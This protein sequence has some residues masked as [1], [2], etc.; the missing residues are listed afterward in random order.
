MP[1]PFLVIGGLAAL[2]AFGAKKGYDAYSDQST[3]NSVNEDATE[4]IEAAK[5]K[6]KKYKK[7]CNEAITSLG[8]QKVFVLDNSV[9]EFLET[10]SKIRNKASFKEANFDDF[11]EGKAQYNDLKELSSMATSIAGGLASGSVAGAITAFGAYGAVS[12][13]AAAS[14]GTAISTLGG[15]AATNATLAFLGGGTL[16]AGGLGVAGGMAVLGG[17]VAAPALAIIGVFA[18]SKA[19][20]NKDEAY[21]NLAKAEE[22]SE[23]VKTACVAISTIRR[24]AAMYERVLMRLDALFAPLVSKMTEIVENSGTDASTYTE[25]ENKVIAAACAL[26]RQISNITNTALLTQDGKVNKSAEKAA[27]QASE[28]IDEMKA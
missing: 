16:A 18:S 6:D 5:K 25:D 13:F 3:A 27:D 4:L 22:Y 28:A 8:Y 1:I 14:T 20:A 24:K 19:S 7:H 11:S 12:T 10:F 23:A 17:L 15:V 2:G 26:A 9:K 21:S